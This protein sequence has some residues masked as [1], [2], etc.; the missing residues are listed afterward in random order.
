MTRLTVVMGVTSCGKSTVGAALASAVGGTYIEGDD[1]HPQA[2]IDKMSSGTPLTDDDRWP[3]LRTLGR[4]MGAESGV[5]VASCSSL[6]RAYRDCIS[7]SAEEPVMFV[8]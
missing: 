4:T 8:Y 3:W 6:K 5:V 2:N 1:L 7:E